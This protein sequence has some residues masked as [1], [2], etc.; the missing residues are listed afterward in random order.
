M[1]TTYA[2]LARSLH[3]TLPG[4]PVLS[5]KV[6]KTNLADWCVGAAA[7]TA[8]TTAVVPTACHH[9]EKLLM[10]LSKCT[11]KVLIRPW[12]ISTPA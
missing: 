8:I 6:W 3:P 9:I 10:Y 1:M 5:M 4:A 11:P 2:G 7:R 12:Q